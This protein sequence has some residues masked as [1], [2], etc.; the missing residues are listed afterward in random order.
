MDARYLGSTKCRQSFNRSNEVR[1]LIG[2]LDLAVDLKIANVWSPSQRGHATS[3]RSS[4]ELTIDSPVYHL[5]VVKITSP[6][7]PAPAVYMTPEV[8]AYV[9]TPRS[10]RRYGPSL[11]DA[12]D[13]AVDRR[14]AAVR[15]PL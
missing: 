14:I 6:P 11:T 1:S 3:F 10:L 5:Q 8:E 2:W 13:L 12:L 15:L 7:V 4:P 9:E